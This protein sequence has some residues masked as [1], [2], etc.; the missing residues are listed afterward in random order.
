MKE[1]IETIRRNWENGSWQPTRVEFWAGA[2]LLITDQPLDETAVVV[3]TKYAGEVSSLIVELRD[4]LDGYIDFTNKY[5]FYTRIGEAANY[6]IRRIGDDLSVI[7]TAILDEAFVIADEWDQYLYFAY[8]SNMDEEQMADRCP[9][10][11]VLK[12]AEIAD[13]QFAIDNRGVATI[14]PKPG[15]KVEGLLWIV[16]Q[17]NIKT[18]DG[19]EGV[20]GGYYRK[21][22]LTVEV[23]GLQH[24]VLVYLSNAKCDRPGYRQGYMQKIID[25]AKE[26]KLSK[27]YIDELSSWMKY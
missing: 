14:L 24:E 2:D 11:K 4:R 9:G 20:A 6:S 16:S 3:V 13:Y 17:R 15:S 25:A 23:N 1:I 5:E 26:H 8:G 27:E 22:T 7:V 12:K 19:Y 18:L 10:A 21:E